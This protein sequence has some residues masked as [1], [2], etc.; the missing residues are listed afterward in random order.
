MARPARG[1]ADPR[2]QLAGEDDRGRRIER[3]CHS[4]DQA[5]YES[6]RE[7]LFGEILAALDEAMGPFAGRHS[8]FTR[9]FVTR[10]RDGK[11]KAARKD[12]GPG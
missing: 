6:A 9:E 3:A 8:G 1:A 7:V 12:S 2:R 4:Y 10:I 5:A 11:V